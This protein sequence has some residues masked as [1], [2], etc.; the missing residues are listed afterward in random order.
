M[1]FPFYHVNCQWLHRSVRAE[2]FTS[3]LPPSEVLPFT[4]S[5]LHAPPPSGL[6]FLYQTHLGLPFQAAAPKTLPTAG[7][8]STDSDLFQ[9]L[10][11]SDIVV[12]QNKLHLCFSKIAIVSAIPCLFGIS[13]YYCRHDLG[14]WVPSTWS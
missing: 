9:G 8:P 10:G 2:I 12:L 4:F 6:L 14:Q 3:L 5:V 7:L 13:V 11:E 1:S